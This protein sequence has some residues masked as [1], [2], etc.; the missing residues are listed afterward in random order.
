MVVGYTRR[1]DPR[2]VGQRGRHH[3]LPAA[4]EAGNSGPRQLAG[5]LVGALKGAARGI[6]RG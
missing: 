2:S 1:R 4:F 6:R 3:V 5:A